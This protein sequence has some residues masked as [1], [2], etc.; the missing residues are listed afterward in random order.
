[1]KMIGK[2]VLACSISV[3]FI[4]TAC[5]KE[6]SDFSSVNTSVSQNIVTTENT[7]KSSA[8]T[9]ELS[10]PKDIIIDG[11]KYPS[12]TTKLDIFL[13]NVN[14]INK[15]SCLTKL[16][17]LR[18][19]CGYD[20]HI[21]L[22]FLKNVKNLEILEIGCN[23]ITDITPISNLTK[24]KELTVKHS[25]VSDISPLKSLINLTNIHM[26]GNHISDISC[27]SGLVNL[28]N[29]GLEENEIED[30]SV[31]K[32]WPNLKC[33]CISNNKISDISCLASLKEDVYLSI[34]SNP[35]PYNQWEYV[36][37]LNSSSGILIYE[38][39]GTKPCPEKWID[40]LKENSK[41]TIIF[42]DYDDYD[43][44]GENEAFAFVGE[45]YEF[46]YLGNLFYLSKDGIK[47]V[48]N[49]NC[50]GFGCYVSGLFRYKDTKIIKIEFVDAVT[51]STSYLYTVDQN[52]P[53]ELNIS[54][55][56][57]GFHM[58]NDNTSCLLHSVY[59]GSKMGCGHTYKPYY[60]YFD[61]ENFI[62]YG[63]IEIT[64]DQFLKFDNAQKIVDSIHEKGNEITTIYYR[65][66][67]LININCIYSGESF[68]PDLSYITV[69][70]DD[71][72]VS[73]LE[74]YM[75]NY[76]PCLIEKYAT[77]PE[78]FNEPQN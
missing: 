14:D 43:G 42:L 58:Y 13:E 6:D 29:V 60:F 63:G 16:K 15:I 21:D 18:I 72:S 51:S 7:D 56:G 62:E 41:G 78:K 64:L 68:D 55:Y 53:K 52:S 35:V 45:P 67:G 28:E 27:L 31:V 70:Y 11:E 20:D 66:K 32:N 38:N 8:V 73:V 47:N 65:D 12:T 5:K 36:R 30:I 34:R 50:G 26:T 48:N 40:L 37:H 61:G 49:F 71:T 24:L 77:F 59:D 22:S 2:L 4:L 44:N 23:S 19:S 3:F 46:G 17:E 76:L 25:E 1:M 39:S 10:E 33:L 74:E 57:Q 69:K 9:T 75:G 54:G